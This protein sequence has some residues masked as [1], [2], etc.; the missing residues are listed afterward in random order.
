MKFVSPSQIDMN[1]PG[2]WPI[3]Y[4]V[5]AWIIIVVLIIFLAYRFMITPVE[6]EIQANETKIENAKNDYQRLYQYTLDLSYYK[7]RSEELIEQLK[8]QLAFLPTQSQMPEL[9]NSVYEAA[10]DNDINIGDFTPAKNAIV[11]EY[12][13]ISSIF[14]A[15]TT[16]FE[17]FSKFTEQLTKLERIMNIADVSMTIAPANRD[18]DSSLFWANNAISVTGQ[19]QTYIYNQDI[20][21]LSRGELPD[22]DK[23]GK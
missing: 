23:K 12:Y 15:T 19:L 22:D 5:I 8:T 16:Y 13:D 1:N 7:K 4:K 6:E 10:I 9:I 21:K 18:K 11:Q 3:Y 14:M 20:E 17:N 2:S